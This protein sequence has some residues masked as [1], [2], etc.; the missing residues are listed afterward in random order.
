MLSKRL[1]RLQGMSEKDLNYYIDLPYKIE[2]TL[3]QDG[4]GFN[5]AIP[6]LKGCMAFGETVEEALETLAEIKQ[7]W[8]EIA[9]ARGWR[10]PEPQS[11]EYKEYSGRFNVRLPRYLHREI[12]QM[13]DREGTSL[14]QLVVAFLSEGAERQRQEIWSVQYGT[15]LELVRFMKALLTYTRHCTT[16]QFEEADDPW[17]L[18]TRAHSR[19]RS[20]AQEVYAPPV[21]GRS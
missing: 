7:A 20:P 2:I 4:T 17:V 9:L 16:W 14:N 13:A 18:T 19:V 21:F 12:A 11:E 8:F 5:V 15:G 1:R 3:E 6:D 10:I